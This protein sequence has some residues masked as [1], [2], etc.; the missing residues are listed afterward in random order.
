MTTKEPK[1]D[2]LDRAGPGY[3]LKCNFLSAGAAEHTVD[4]EGRVYTHRPYA[5]RSSLRT[6]RTRVGRRCLSEVLGELLEPPGIS[7][8]Q[9]GIA[10]GA[11]NCPRRGRIA[12]QGAARA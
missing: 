5:N 1:P 12:E 8:R 3:F 4:R 6:H 10:T 11:G 9:P 7:Y 2:K